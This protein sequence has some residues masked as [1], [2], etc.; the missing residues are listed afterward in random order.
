LIDLGAGTIHLFTARSEQERR[1]TIRAVGPVW[2]G[3]EVWLLAAEGTL[4]FA[5]PLL[6]A[7]GFSGCKSPNR[8]G[9][10]L[11]LICLLSR[12][13][14]AGLTRSVYREITNG[15]GEGVGHESPEG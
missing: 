4:F 11:E 10:W 14:Q 15:T 13:D 3:N 6:Y 2:D 8:F 5:F 7:S 12:F 9:G 1:T